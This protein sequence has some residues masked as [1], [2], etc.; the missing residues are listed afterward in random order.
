MGKNIYIIY[1]QLYRNDRLTH[2]PQ[3]Y[4]SAQAHE[5]NPLP[6]GK[7]VRRD[8]SKWRALV[9]EGNTMEVVHG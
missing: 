8:S 3:M 9:A 6:A 2:L 4:L 7:D 1:T 5:E